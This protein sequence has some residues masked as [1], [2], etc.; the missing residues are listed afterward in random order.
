M[1]LQERYLNDLRCVV[2]AVGHLIRPWDTHFQS[3]RLADDWDWMI[4]G[5][6]LV[7]DDDDDEDERQYTY[8]VQLMDTSIYSW[9]ISRNQMVLQHAQPQKKKRTAKQPE[10]QPA[11]G[12]SSEPSTYILEFKMSVWGV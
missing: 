7:D 3:N 1:L 11:P 12:K 9:N 2:H 8:S 4:F 10:A 5:E 6:K